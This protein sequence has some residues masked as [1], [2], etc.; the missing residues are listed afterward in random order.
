M[1]RRKPLLVN[2]IKVI[3]DFLFSNIIYVIV[4][5]LCMSRTECASMRRQNVLDKQ[6]FP[7]QADGSLR[8]E[9]ARILAYG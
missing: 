1:R 4:F 6:I 8:G 5:P 2:Q 9:R 7:A 3:I